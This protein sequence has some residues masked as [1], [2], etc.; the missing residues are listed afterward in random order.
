M[1][2]TI[3]FRAVLDALDRTKAGTDSADRRFR[4][5]AGKIGK[6]FTDTL[7]VFGAYA[8]SGRSVALRDRVA[9]HAD[10]G[11]GRGRTRPHP[12]DRNGPPVHARS[13]PA[14]AG[15]IRGRRPP[16]HGLVEEDGKIW[17]AVV[18]STQDGA[19]TSLMTLHRG[20]DYGIRVAR[21]RFK[22]IR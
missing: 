12:R 7:A 2:D 11:G 3:R 1:A 16:S 22:Q 13:I 17:R 5:L 20:R 4:S 15:G 18:K 19:K 9:G 8:S 14:R 10:P 21:R 6:Y